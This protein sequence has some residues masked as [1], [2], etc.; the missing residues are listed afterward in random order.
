MS[1]SILGM[2]SNLIFGK[3]KAEFVFIAEYNKLK[4]YIYR[5]IN[6]LS[7]KLVHTVKVQ[8]YLIMK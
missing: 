7:L 1:A 2:Q 3:H 8:I 5:I 6:V 4:A